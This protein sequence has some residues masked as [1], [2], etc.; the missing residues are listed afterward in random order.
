MSD[1]IPGKRVLRSNSR[2]D[3]AALEL[4][5]QPQLSSQTIIEKEDEHLSD[6]MEAKRK[7]SLDQVNRLKSAIENEERFAGWSKGELSE[8]V[9][10]L[11]ELNSNLDNFNMHLTCED[12]LSAE[13][14]AENIEMDDLI[15][16]LKAK[17]RDR[18][19]VL[20]RQND[21]ERTQAQSQQ[22]LRIE[23]QQTDATG[24]VPNTWGTFNGDYA[25]WKSFR[26]R[27]L[28]AMH[29]NT[30]IQVVTKFNNLKTACIGEAAG[31]L[32]DWDLTEENYDKAWKRLKKIYEDDYMQVQAFMQMLNKL[33]RMR[34]NSSKTIRTIIDTIQKHVNGLKSY[35]KTDD[36]YP[37]VVFTV[38]D[39]MDTAT[40]SAWEKHRPSLALAANQAENEAGSDDD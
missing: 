26:D 7:Y 16:N 40:Y 28:A 2:A 4:A 10:R 25:K 34:D 5:P 9:K 8:R 30:K 3:R 29:T 6:G 23:V 1:I 38:I 31:A 15:M 24:N 36:A 19:E 11:E 20:G 33:P 27:W 14:S 13:Q 18:I 22:P 21:T 12:K 17:L 32:G 39:R 35:I 37:Y